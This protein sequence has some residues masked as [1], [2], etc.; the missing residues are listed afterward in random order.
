ME[1]VSNVSSEEE[2]LELRNEG[3]ISEDEYGELLETLRK[4]AKVDVGPAGPCESKPVSTSGLAI[5]SLVFS[6]IVPFGCIPAVICG[7]LALGRIKKEPALQGRRLALAGLIIGYVVL[8]LCAVIYAW[9]EGGPIEQA[10]RIELL[11]ISPAELEGRIQPPIEVTE[12]K[13][14]PLDSIDGVLTQSA[15]QINTAKA[16]EKLEKLSGG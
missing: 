1:T 8:G 7:H 13:Q 15:V 14:H 16:E 6:L 10:K 2:L 5:A 9:R 4:S 12:P 11:S 3:K